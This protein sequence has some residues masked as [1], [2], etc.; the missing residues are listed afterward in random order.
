MF[1]EGFLRRVLMFIGVILSGLITLIFVATPEPFDVPVPDDFPN[2]TTKSGRIQQLSIAENYFDNPIGD[3]ISGATLSSVVSWST[4][5]RYLLTNVKISTA[6]G[7]KT[8]AYVLDLVRRLYVP[9]PNASWIDT[10]SW[11]G[12]RLLYQTDTKYAV[13]DIATG[14]SHTFGGGN[15]FG[16]PLFSPDGTKVAYAD[17]GIIFYNLATQKNVRISHDDGDVPV[18]WYMN[19]RKLLFTKKI[20]SGAVKKDVVYQYDFD[21]KIA[22][23]LTPLDKP[24]KQATWLVRDEVAFIT[25]GTD[26]GNFEYL[27]NVTTGESKFITETSEGRAFVSTQDDMLVVVEGKVATLYSKTLDIVKKNILAT[28]GDVRSVILLS[29]QRLIVVQGVAHDASVVT[30][31]NMEKKTETK[32]ADIWLPYVF[33]SPDG[34]S[35]ATVATGN[36]AAKFIP[37]PRE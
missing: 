16:K 35:L 25:L 18:L 11:Y 5:S 14:E 34:T 32:L 23:P 21:K 4:N 2:I 1:N 28:K 12:T 9:V 31:V 22:T 17:H 26:D 33:A 15:I 20:E 7:T 24:F 27:Y 19:G 6:E 3:A 29:N 37:V 30:L 8:Q 10:A 36:V 13:F